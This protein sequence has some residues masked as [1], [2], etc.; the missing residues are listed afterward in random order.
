[1]KK[2]KVF[3][4]ALGIAFA[5]M[6]MTACHKHHDHSAADSDEDAEVGEIVVTNLSA[7]EEI[8]SNTT[9]MLNG[10]T[11]KVMFLPKNEFIG[12]RF[13]MS[14][15]QLKKLNDSLFVA[16]N[17]KAGLTVVSLVAEL[18]EDASIKVQKDIEVNVP[19]SYAIVPFV[20]QASQDL[21]QFTTAEVTYT[22]AAGEKHI[23]T[24]DNKDWH[25]PDSTSIFHYDT[26][27]PQDGWT[28]IEERKLAPNADFTFRVR[29]YQLGIDASVSVRYVA[30]ANVTLSADSYYF[31]HDLDR[32][33]AEIV[34]PNTIVRD[35][36][37]ST[38]F[39]LTNHDV[40]K[41]DVPAY[42]ETLKSE[43]DVFNLNISAK[44]DITEKK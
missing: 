11:L 30:K 44:G 17:H 32:Y 4:V 23:F 7:Q 9:T 15:S 26:D 40:A 31:Y 42:L 41:A 20:L 2:I 34:V 24:I 33:S 39:D 18:E 35:I 3:E 5:A 6:I 8:T 13:T 27:T 14:S 16:N 1:M 12:K 29:Y 19:S 10:D 43:P 21:L 22:D 25:R 37:N 36:Y 38:R 28:L